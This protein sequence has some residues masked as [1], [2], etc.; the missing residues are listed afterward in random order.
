[1]GADAVTLRFENSGNVHVVPRGI[2]TLTDPIGR[3]VGRGILNESSSMILPE[4][5]RFYKT[6]LRR[7]APLFVPG[8]YSLTISYRYDGKNEFEAVSSKIF[9]FPWQSI[10]GIVTTIVLGYYILRFSKKRLSKN[11]I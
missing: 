11:K 9:F 7:L 8:W 2:L 1:L 5:Q 10:V 3:T 6:E 4:S